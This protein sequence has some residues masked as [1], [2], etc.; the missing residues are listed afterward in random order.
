MRSMSHDARRWT[1]GRRRG[2]SAIADQDTADSSGTRCF[3][4]RVL[5]AEEHTPRAVGPLSSGEGGVEKPRRRFAALTRPALM[6]TQLHRVEVGAPDSELPHQ[7]TLDQQ[8]VRL[9]QRAGGNP[10]L[11]GDQH[12]PGAGVVESS[13][14]GHRVRQQDQ[15][16]RPIDVPGSMLVEGSVAIQENDVVRR[17]RAGRGDRP[18]APAEEFIVGESHAGEPALTD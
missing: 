12:D 15:I 11:V 7:F 3:D 16:A 9:A 2:Q 13:D 10:P 1:T 5:I 6:R 4:I 17:V 14:R 18:S 8:K